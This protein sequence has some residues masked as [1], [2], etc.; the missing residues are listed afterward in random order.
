MA[1]HRHPRWLT[2]IIYLARGT[3]RHQVNDTVYQ[4]RAGDVLVVHPGDTH[5]TAGSPEQRSTV[6]WIGLRIPGR[7]GP[8]FLDLAPHASGAMVAAIRGIERRL[9]RCPPSVG[10]HL[11]GALSGLL[12][13]MRD[14]LDPLFVRANLLFALTEIIAGAHRR[15]SRKQSNAMLEMCSFIDARI[16]GGGRSDT[17]RLTTAA[18]AARFGLSR[19]RLNR[20]FLRETGMPP[21]EY[22]LRRR[23]EG[24]RRAI[25]DAPGRNF[26]DIAAEFG[27][28]SSQYL[29]TA[30][31]R[32]EGVTPTEWRRRANAPPLR[33][34]AR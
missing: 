4:M 30:F 23:I 25:L 9:F 8:G 32:H 28:P 31:K 12:D 24:V 15:Y 34:P 7:G 5:G 10:G 3:Q 21:A 19:S 20:L 17:P 18:L 11:D 1:K 13:E 26:A 6:Y 14:P 33:S 29:A 16:S 2:E 22:V 27:F